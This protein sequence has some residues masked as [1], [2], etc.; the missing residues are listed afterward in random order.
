MTKAHNDRAADE[1]REIKSLNKSIFRPSFTW[2]KSAK[3]DAA[4]RKILDRHHEEREEREET[5][6]QVFESRE[7]IGN[8]FR[9]AERDQRAP[10]QYSSQAANS[11][12]SKLSGRSRYQFE[13]DE[14]DD[15]VES[16]L[17]SNLDEIGQLSK[18]LNLLARAAGEEVR[19]QNSKLDTLNNKTDRYVFLRRDLGYAH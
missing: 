2:N 17:N 19:T 18:S 7:R 3:R 16:E 13:A 1:A 12:A 14:E 6:R 8:T 9:Q 4:E 5:R 10:G 15:Q 11:A